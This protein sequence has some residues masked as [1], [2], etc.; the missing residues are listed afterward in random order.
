MSEQKTVQA[1]SMT[2]VV[3]SDS[4]EKTVSVKVTTFKTHRLYHKRYRWTKNYL[5][6]VGELEP[7]VGDTVKIVTGKPISKRKR[8]TVTEIIT[9]AGNQQEKQVR[10][11]STKSSTKASTAR[12]KAK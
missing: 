11:Q 12:K 6:D 7:K 5:S 8:W 10:K 2:G 4:M 9:E 3:V 1:K